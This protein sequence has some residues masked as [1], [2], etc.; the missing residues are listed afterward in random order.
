[1]SEKTGPGG[2]EYQ[3]IADLVAKQVTLL[4]VEG[5]IDSIDIELDGMALDATVAKE[6]TL[7]VPAADS[8]ANTTI[9]EVAGTKTDT[10]VL[11]VDNPDATYSLMRMLKAL[12]AGFSYQFTRGATDGVDNSYIRDVIGSKTDTTAGNSIIS[13]LKKIFN[14]TSTVDATGTFS[15]LDAGVEQTIYELTNSTRKIING[16][17]L[18]LVNMTQNGTIKLYYKIDGTNYRVIDTVDYTVGVDSVGLLISGPISIT[19]DFKVS[20][21]EDSDEGADRNIPYTMIYEV[22]E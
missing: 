8:V 22:K 17:W 20:Y 4:L 19:E 5:K 1:M 21:T 6:A 3:E 12:W 15:Y 7:A 18:D 9:A 14:I 10:F 13:W 2:S 11:G 16:I